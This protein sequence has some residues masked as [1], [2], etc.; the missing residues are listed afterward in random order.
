MKFGKQH[1]S[2]LIKIQ[3]LSLL[4]NGNQRLS[5]ISEEA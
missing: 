4:P 3:E 5:L 1:L 2:Q